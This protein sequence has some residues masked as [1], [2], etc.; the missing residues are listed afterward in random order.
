MPMPSPSASGDI[1]DSLLGFRVEKVVLINSKFRQC[2]VFNFNVM[3]IV[4][5]HLR[6]K[7]ITITKDAFYTYDVLYILCDTLQCFIISVIFTEDCI[8]VR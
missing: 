6:N 2:S 1:A 5:F 7:N 3:S 8:I 4:V